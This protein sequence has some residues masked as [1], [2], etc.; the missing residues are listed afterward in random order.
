M[1]RLAPRLARPTHE[2]DAPGV[3]TYLTRS[4]RIAADAMFGGVR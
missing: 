2:V 3:R 1:N 4:P